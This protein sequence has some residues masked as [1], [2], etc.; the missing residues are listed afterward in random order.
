[1]T[2]DMMNNKALCDHTGIAE[3]DIITTKWTSSD[4]HP[5]HYIALDHSTKS[6]IIAIRGS[7]H[8][9][10]ALVD[11]VAAASPFQGGYA[12]TGMLECAR[13]KLMMIRIPLLQ[14]IAKHHGYS[15]VIIGHSLGA[16][17][18]ALLTLLLKNEIPCSTPLRCYAYA[19]PCV[20]SPQLAKSS[21]S[22][23]SSFV[24]GNDCVPRLSYASIAK[25]K[26]LT[27]VLMEQASSG[28]SV[29]LKA[30]RK[31]ID[32]GKLNQELA[33]NLD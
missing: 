8:V 3:E 25:L 18:A 31:Q 6:I 28:V 20:L 21:E 24:L 14:A 16:G 26:N 29:L 2:G 10:D 22:M 15:V 17:T 13:R 1:M 11:L 23:I 4:Y 12:H 30:K 9:K 27:G 32:I 5:A 7:F 33:F 19:P